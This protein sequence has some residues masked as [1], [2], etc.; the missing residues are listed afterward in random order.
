MKCECV[1]LKWVVGFLPFENEKLILFLLIFDEVLSTNN[2]EP[3]FAN[4]FL[5]TDDFIG[6]SRVGVQ[7]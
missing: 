6:L 3:V 4:R 2:C 1:I 5:D 7:K